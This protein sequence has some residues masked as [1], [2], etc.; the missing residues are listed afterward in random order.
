MLIKEIRYVSIEYSECTYSLFI[1][2]SFKFSSQDSLTFYGKLKSYFRD[3][4]KS[5]TLI[6]FILFYVGLI[7]RFT[8]GSSEEDFI[9]ARFVYFII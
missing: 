4:F 7:V 8:N 3:V 9:A 1:F 6:A 5:M 2:P